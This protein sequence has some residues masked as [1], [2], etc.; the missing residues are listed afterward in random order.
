[1][2]KNNWMMSILHNIVQFDNQFLISKLHEPD[3]M[4]QTIAILDSF[5]HV[6]NINYS[7]ET[8]D[9][10]DVEM[11]IQRGQVAVVWFMTGVAVVWFMTGVYRRESPC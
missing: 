1:M 9:G 10:A 2:M 4:S 7:R 3:Y 11:E 8:R 5:I 6:S